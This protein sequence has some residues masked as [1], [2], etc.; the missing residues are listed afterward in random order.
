MAAEHIYL[1]FGCVLLPT[2]HVVGRQKGLSF[3]KLDHDLGNKRGIWLV[4]INRRHNSLIW[5]ETCMETKSNFTL[6]IHGVLGSCD[7]SYLRLLLI[8]QSVAKM[9]LFC[10]IKK[11]IKMLLKV[12]CV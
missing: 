4:K 10:A 12:Q 6:A 7:I 11:S 8:I 2:H 1:Q 5:V 3:T 9:K